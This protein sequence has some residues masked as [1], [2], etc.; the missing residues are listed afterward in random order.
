MKK[1][2]FSPEALTEELQ[3]E[4]RS[5]GLPESS[6]NLII[7]KVLKAVLTWLE[8]RDIIT[9]S[10]LERV[11][12]HELDKYSTDLAFLYQHRDKLI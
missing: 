7:E 6:T 9:K 1:Q 11:V 2:T 4:S 5:L 8:N 10:D 12:S 3:K